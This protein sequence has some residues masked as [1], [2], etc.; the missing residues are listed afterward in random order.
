MYKHDMTPTMAKK[1]RLTRDSNN[2]ILGGVCAGIANYLDT[3]PT[4]IRLIWAIL[5]FFTAIIG[6]TLL[7]LIAWIIMP[8]E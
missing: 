1:K 4:I 6:G 2:K 3:D 5:T 7:Y 8:E